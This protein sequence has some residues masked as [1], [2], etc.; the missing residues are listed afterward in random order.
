MSLQIHNT[1]ELRQA[2]GK[3]T[4]SFAIMLGGGIS[5]SCKTI[6]LMKDKKRFRVTNHIDG[7]RQS[8]TGR[9]LYTH[10]NIGKA[11]KLK[12]FWTD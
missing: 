6:T 2:I 10:S 4:T 8:L 11:M 5:M 9:Q 1:K 7:S 12:A 3:G